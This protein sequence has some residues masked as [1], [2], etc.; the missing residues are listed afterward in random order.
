MSGANER[1]GW[2]R[3]HTCGELREEHAGSGAV[4]NGW[5]AS[6]RNLGGIYF[7][8]LRD[9]YGV[10]QV[11]LPEDLDASAKLAREDCI[12]VTGE[13]TLREA[14][15]D[16]LPTGMVELRAASVEKLSASKTPP[17]EIEEDLDTSVELRLQYR[18]LDLRR[19]RM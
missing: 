14:P 2:Q 9:R 12:S 17:F 7:I 1:S 19:E 8:D 10:T 16:R 15:N 13:V 3:T 4:L 6:R 5:V 11:V 18:Y